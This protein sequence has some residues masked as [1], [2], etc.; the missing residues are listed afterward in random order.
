LAKLTWNIFISKHTNKNTLAFSSAI[1]ASLPRGMLLDKNGLKL[2]TPYK[3]FTEWC[4]AYLSGDWATTKVKGGFIIVINEK[5]D[6]KKIQEEFKVIGEVKIT[7]ASNNTFPIGYND[8]QYAAL[9]GDLGYV[10]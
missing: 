5:S 3:L 8:S 4:S 10:L 6:G 2:P 7:N 9:A 1:S